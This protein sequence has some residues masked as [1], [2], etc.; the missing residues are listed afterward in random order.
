[1]WSF[2]KFLCFLPELW[3]FGC[4]KKCI[5]LQFCA[6]LCKK[7]KSVKI[8]Y[9]YASENSHCTLSENDMVCVGLSHRS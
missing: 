3:F 6:D 2:V 9:I 7:P 4:P 5:F 8:S 1:M